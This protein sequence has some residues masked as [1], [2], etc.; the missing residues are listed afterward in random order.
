LAVPNLD[1]QLKM[2]SQIQKLIP[3]SPI[4]ASSD[5]MAAPP[6]FSSSTLPGLLVGC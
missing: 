4:G 5:P 2:K 3:R 6:C 1:T